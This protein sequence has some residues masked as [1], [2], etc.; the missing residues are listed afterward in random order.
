MEKGRGR[1]GENLKQAPRSAQ[2]PTRGSI[3]RRWDHGLGRNQESDTQRTEPP[4]RPMEMWG[5]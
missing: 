1:E 2:S 5:F 4:G 3:P